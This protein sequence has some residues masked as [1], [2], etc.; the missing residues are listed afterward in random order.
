M[1]EL[2][3][4]LFRVFLRDQKPRTVFLKDPTGHCKDKGNG[5]YT[6]GRSFDNRH[7]RGGYIDIN[8]ELTNKIKE[9]SKEL[10]DMFNLL[11]DSFDYKTLDI[12]PQTGQVIINH[13]FLL[14]IGLSYYKDR[15]N[16]NRLDN[17]MIGTKYHL[18]VNTGMISYNGNTTNNYINESSRWAI[19]YRYNLA[20]M[21]QINIDAK[22]K[23]EQSLRDLG[24]DDY[25]SKIQ[26]A[27]KSMHF[28]GNV[29]GGGVIADFILSV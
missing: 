6:I 15:N 17:D 16:L 13:N 1:K 5:S 14:N 9:G 19:N 3:E 10:R 22:N 7:F 12:D 25:K 18:N 24:A 4:N 27:Y 28:F 21:K 20:E 11:N 2:M 8:D 29:Q 23:L 26:K